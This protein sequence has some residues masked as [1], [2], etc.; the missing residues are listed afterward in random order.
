MGTLFLSIEVSKAA[1]KRAEALSEGRTADA[2][3]HAKEVDAFTRQLDES[4]PILTGISDA[5]TAEGAALDRGNQEEAARHAAEKA[6][7]NERLQEVSNKYKELMK[8][9]R[10]ERS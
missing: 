5:M 8:T 2:A 10:E 9:L 1:E 3:F 6:R 4:N 7:G